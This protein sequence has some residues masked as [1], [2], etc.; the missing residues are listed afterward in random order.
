MDW[1]GRW[2]A[3]NK[4]FLL[5]CYA[6]PNQG[7]GRLSHSLVW[8]SCT[9]FDLTV[10][11]L[12]YRHYCWEIEVVCLA[13]PA[14]FCKSQGLTSLSQLQFCAVHC[15][16]QINFIQQKLHIESVTNTSCRSLHATR[17][18]N[19]RKFRHWLDTFPPSF[20][21][22]NIYT[23]KRVGHQSAA[24]TSFGSPFIIRT[25]IG[26]RRGEVGRWWQGKDPTFSEPPTE[27]RS[28]SRPTK[29]ENIRHFN[30]LRHF[31][32]LCHFFQAWGETPFH[33]LLYW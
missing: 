31:N 28:A 18:P 8:D 24:Q 11:S 14:I 21:L 23:A 29:L 17:W 33:W 2:D 25:A 20:T 13:V 10:L 7:R 6:H 27:G 26:G 15:F 30:I 4:V 32:A 12:K 22:A 16:A 5:V 9:T 3:R 19:N 1:L